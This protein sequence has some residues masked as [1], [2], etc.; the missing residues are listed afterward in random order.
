MD[1]GE[2]ERGYM[3]VSGLGYAPVEDSCEYDTKPSGSIKCW[4][5]LEWLHKWQL[6]EKGSAA[7]S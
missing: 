1:L 6:L 5:V 7:R 3:N 2:M 4:E